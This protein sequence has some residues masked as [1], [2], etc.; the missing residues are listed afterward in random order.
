MANFFLFLSLAEIKIL[1]NK[2]VGAQTLN[3]CQ[4]VQVSPMVKTGPLKGRSIKYLY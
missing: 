4:L 1:R 3:K 2:G